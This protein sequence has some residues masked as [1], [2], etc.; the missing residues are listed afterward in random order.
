MDEVDK[1]QV[2]EE[3]ILDVDEA[4][5]ELGELRQEFDNLCLLVDRM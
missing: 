2:W 1:A 5:R 3:L 4:K